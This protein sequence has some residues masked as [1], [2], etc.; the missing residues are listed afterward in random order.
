MSVQQVSGAAPSA[1]PPTP[2][3]RRRRSRD[4]SSWQHPR[5]HQSGGLI[6]HGAGRE[7]GEFC[8]ERRAADSD[9]A[10][11]KAAV[12]RT[13]SAGGRR[14]MLLAAAAAAAADICVHG[15]VAGRR[16]RRLGYRAAQQVGRRR[17][18]PRGRSNA[19]WLRV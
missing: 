17:R 4:P 19:T 9:G 1:R 11:N 5:I 3:R 10:A 7:C 13:G 12:L 6:L 16:V 14:P 2:H 18:P 15:S 8:P